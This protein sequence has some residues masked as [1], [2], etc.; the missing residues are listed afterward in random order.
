M[1]EKKIDEDWKDQVEREKHAEA[2]EPAASEE[3]AS[4][5]EPS[6]F[7]HVTSIATQ[8]MLSFG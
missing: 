7:T 5:P 1:D 8:V 4:L 2:E 3:E 6:F